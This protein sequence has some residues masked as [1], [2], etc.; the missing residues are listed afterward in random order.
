MIKSSIQTGFNGAFKDAADFNKKMHFMF[1]ST[2]TG[3]NSPEAA[4]DQ[5]KAHGINVIF[6]ESQ[7]MAHEWLTW[8]TALNDFAPRLFK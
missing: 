6:H 3:E 7:G 2:R 8:R 1:T 5:L 4:V